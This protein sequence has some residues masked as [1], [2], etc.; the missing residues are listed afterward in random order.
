MTTATTTELYRALLKTAQRWPQQQRAQDMTKMIIEQ[1][2]Q[3]FRED[4]KMK[5]NERLAKGQEELLAMRQMLN[6]DLQTKV[7]LF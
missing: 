6:N 2:K 1:I 7:I 4:S 5:I 3:K